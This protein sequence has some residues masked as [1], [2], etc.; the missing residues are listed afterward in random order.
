MQFQ[1]QSSFT[2][3][4]IKD[5]VELSDIILQIHE[6]PKDV[7]TTLANEVGLSAN[8]VQEGR[9]GVAYCV[10]KGLKVSHPLLD[11]T[12][13]SIDGKPFDE[14]VAILRQCTHFV[15]FDPDTFFSSV[16]C[17]LGC[18]SIVEADLKPDELEERKNNL[19][20]ISWDGH[21]LEETWNYRQQLLDKFDKNECLN[22]SCVQAFFNFWEERL[23]ASN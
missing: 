12:A 5:F 19:G 23:N 9:Q 4:F 10:R 21:N 6:T 3:A 17:A 1:Y 8:V 14:V 2:P 13:I 22:K 7:Y 11:E 16:A 15:S 20:F 18:F